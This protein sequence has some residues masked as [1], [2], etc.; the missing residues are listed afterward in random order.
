VSDADRSQLL[1]ASDPRRT[2]E[3]AY[4]DACPKLCRFSCP[5]SEAERRETVTPWAKMDV[6]HQRQT[7]ARPLDA[8]SAEAVYACTGCMR[9]TEHCRHG[10]QVA[11]ALVA[12]RTEAVKE[13]VAPPA[14]KALADR[15]ATHGSPFSTPLREAA[16]SLGAREG[17]SYFPGCTALVKEP[18]VVADA[19][20]AAAG[21]GLPLELS[22]LAGRCCGY[23]LWAAGHPVAFRAHAENFARAA[24]GM[25][26]IVAG[27]PGCAY[28]LTVLYP[29]VEV[30]L[31]PVR[32]WVDE[33]ARRLP[34]EGTGTP[35][36]L[37]AAYHDP[38]HLGRGMGRYEAPRAILQHALGGK[39]FGEA[40][41][42]RH[43]GGCSGG[44][45]LLPRTH[46]ETS[47]EIARR[48]H[49]ALG[50]GKTVVTA[51]PAA[52]RMFEKGGARA[53]NLETLLARYFAGPEEGT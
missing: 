31:P 40:E 13:G 4:C 8:S 19:I 24:S 10:N 23:P 53:I 52:R 47:V 26:S 18:A 9:C 11:P 7:R 16:E 30:S 41:A 14:V 25:P 46:P 36:Q 34:L 21:V 45:G 12:L 1:P 29:Q 17:G 38:C 33:V 27:D 22:P 32:L 5:V 51:C 39:S 48:Q 50:E 49:A 6:G 44:G 42:A 20:R 3:Y 2:R 15:F 43:D 35:V 37:D 28:T